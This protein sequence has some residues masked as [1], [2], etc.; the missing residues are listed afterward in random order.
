[1]NKLRGIAG[2]LIALFALTRW[3]ESLLFEVSPTYP[4]TF[5]GVV[6]LLTLVVLLN[7]TTQHWYISLFFAIFAPLRLGEKLASLCLDSRQGAKARRSQRRGKCT[8]VVWFDLDAAA[9]L[10]LW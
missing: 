9:T 8:N 1:M 4:L 7:R 2:E 10:L 6:L 3:L 5:V